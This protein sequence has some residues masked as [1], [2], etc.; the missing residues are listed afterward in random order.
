MVEVSRIRLLPIKALD[1]VDVDS[2]RRR[3]RT[4]IEI[5]G[6]EPF[7]EDRLFTD[8]DH[9]VEFRIG[10][11]TLHGMMSKPRCV[12]PT[13]HPD[14]GELKEG[15][16]SRF[17]EKREETLPDWAD[18]DHFGHHIAAEVEHYYY[19][20]VVTRIPGTAVGERI[21][22]GDS[23]SVEGPVPLLETL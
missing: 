14:S 13:R 19:L 2:V 12:T 3:L 7:W 20:T 16:T 8:A 22:V 1:G 11:V 9:A 21:A 17:V 5:S 10:D 4:N 18:P 23:V 6:V 15:F